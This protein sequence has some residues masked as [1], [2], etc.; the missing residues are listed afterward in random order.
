MLTQGYWRNETAAAAAFTDSG[1]FRTGDAA[2]LDEAG[3]VFLFDRFKDMTISG[4]ENIYPA[5]IENVLNGHP[6]V[7]EVGVIGVAHDKWGETPLAVVVRG[8]DHTVEADELIAYTRANLATYKCP[9]RVVFTEQ[10]PRNACGKLLKHE[11][12]RIYKATS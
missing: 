10:L 6:A 11:I 5:E 3:H 9:S 7:A 2:Y 4:G 1:W 8:E 12:R